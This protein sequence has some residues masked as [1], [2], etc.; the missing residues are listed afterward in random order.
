M[1]RLG[2]ALAVLVLWTG[3]A[4]AG[5]V[6]IGRIQGRG[7][8][9][10]L[11]GMRVEGV[12]GV[13]TAL[14]PRRGEVGFWMESERP[15]GDP[16]TSEG[17][18]VAHSERLDELAPGHRVAVS[19]AVAEVAFNQGLPVTR[20][21]AEEVRVV[22]SAESLSPP[23]VLGEGGRALPNASVDDDGLTAFEPGQDGADL[24]ES[25]EGMRV[26]I[27]D[28][29][30]VGSTTR[31]G[32][33]VVVAD[34]GRGAGPRTSSGGVRIAPGDANPERIILDDELVRGMPPARVGDRLAGAVVG[35]VDYGWGTYRVQLLE[36][37]EVVPGPLAAGST[38]LRAEEDG[39][40]VA[41]F[42]VENLSA[43]S[44]EA[45]IAALAGLV[46]DA[47]ASPD[48]VALQEIQ[49]A[50]GSQDDGVVDAGP[51]LDG[52]VAAI[53]AAGGPRY[54]WHQ[55]DPADGADGGR[56]GAN[57]RV[58]YLVHP[59]R[60]EVVERGSRGDGTWAAEGGGLT[61][62]PGRVAPRHPAFNLDQGLG[63]GPGRKPLALEVRFRGRRLVLCNLH[64]TSKGGDDPLMALHQPP[65]RPS[66][67][68][69]R[70]QAGV[71]AAL[72]RDLLAEDA[73]ARVVVL[74]DLNEHPFRPALRVLEAAGLTNLTERVPPAD[75]YTYVFR[76]NA[77][78]LDHILVSPALAEDAE[79]E[80]VHV[81]ADRPQ[82]VRASDHDPVVCRLRIP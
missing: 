74:G 43:R 56:P 80:V 45:R 21:R 69:R 53:V 59:R 58:A 30:V 15:D 2:R 18:F 38:T 29:V 71:V 57:I 7:H 72:V 81:N 13:V 54:R 25:L 46:A 12:H 70:E 20:L 63:F 62:S 49:D 78:T 34:G 66:E 73:G 6:T 8:L 11:A 79:V 4:V 82:A 24:L 26:V 10:P 55:V 65:R 61:V 76:G 77:Q 40:T 32:E 19:A 39:L 14:T 48:V 28:A 64:L 27:R 42:N 75:G 47:L 3:A 52:L 37:V 67:A 51:T 68:Q 41:T 44:E 1:G 5:E 50:S 9:S 33:L 23:V 36:P 16:A 31:H 60:V 17:I 35:V 22:G